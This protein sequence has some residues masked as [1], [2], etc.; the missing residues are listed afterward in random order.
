MQVR[1]VNS[2]SLDMSGSKV[3]ITVPISRDV[4]P[5]V[6][7]TKEKYDSLGKKAISEIRLVEPKGHFILRVTRIL[8]GLRQ[9]D[10]AKMLGISLR[11]YQRREMG[12]GGEFTLLNILTI[13]DKF[14]INADTLFFVDHFLNLA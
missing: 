7:L 14:K 6:L 3:K 9:S 12:Q 4:E 1:V 10:M 2:K 5:E 11:T 8:R 13:C